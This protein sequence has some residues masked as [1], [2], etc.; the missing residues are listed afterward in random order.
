MESNLAPIVLFTYNRPEHTEK[1][2]NSLAANK[3]LA[4][5]F[6]GATQFFV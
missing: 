1:T 6:C 4:S 3:Y 5:R 2:L